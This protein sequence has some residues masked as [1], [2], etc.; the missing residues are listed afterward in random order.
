MM[1]GKDDD[2]DDSEYFQCTMDQAESFM[3]FTLSAHFF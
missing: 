1:T 2:D 3:L